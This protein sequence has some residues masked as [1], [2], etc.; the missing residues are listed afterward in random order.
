M[1][2]KYLKL[3]SVVFV[4]SLS[5]VACGG[6]DNNGLPPVFVQAMDPGTGSFHGGTPMVTIWGHGFQQGAKVT[7][8]G[9]RATVYSMTADNIWITAT[10]PHALGAVDVVVTNPDGSSGTC[11]NCFTYVKSSQD[12]AREIMGSNFFGLEENAKYLGYTMSPVDA[13]KYDSVGYTEAT[14]RAKSA[15]HMLVFMYNVSIPDL[16]A[17]LPAGTIAFCDAWNASQ[18]YV[19]YAMPTGWYLVSKD[20]APG[21]L[22]LP[23][24][25]QFGKIAGLPYEAPPQ[26]VTLVYA[27]VAHYV[28]TGEV[29]MPGIFGRTTDNTAP[30]GTNLMTVYAG[31]NAYGAK[32]GICSDWGENADPA[33]GLAS[34][35][36]HI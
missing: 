18:K 7:F 5:L 3:F 32:I 8:G 19:A 2:P 13:A 15:T 35:W 30:G 9:A 29:L 24:S 33:I 11:A 27:L 25:Q 16:Q 6:P 17:K 28:A 20:V 21:S 4:V 14:L 10:P 1:F 36:I 12:I 26:T 34:W 31:G 22:G 23:E